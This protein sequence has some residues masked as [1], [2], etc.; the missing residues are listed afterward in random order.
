MSRKAG[1][2]VRRVFIN[3]FVFLAMFGVSRQLLGSPEMPTQLTYNFAQMPILD[4]ACLD[5]KGSKFFIVTRT[6]WGDDPW[7]RLAFVAR[8]P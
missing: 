4:S 6:T 3:T 1:N 8:H 7:G 5:H 2:V